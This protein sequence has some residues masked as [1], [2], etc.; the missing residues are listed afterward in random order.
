M[1]SVPRPEGCYETRHALA[2]AKPP[3]GGGALEDGGGDPSEDHGPPSP[4]LH[5]AGD[6]ADAATEF[7]PRL[8]IPGEA[9]KKAPE[10]VAF[11][12]SRDPNPAP[13]V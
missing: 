11:S 9:R 7:V 6:V 12:L 5:A 1:L 8:T 3:E 10:G 2:S 4:A 13:A